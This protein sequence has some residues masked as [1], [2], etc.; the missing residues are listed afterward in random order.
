LDIPVIEDKSM[1]KYLLVILLISLILAGCVVS[2]LNPLY[3]DKDLILLPGLEGTWIDNDKNFWTFNKAEDNS[4]QMTYSRDTE[5]KEN[6]EVFDAHLVRLENQIFMDLFP[7]EGAFRDN[8]GMMAGHY[9]PTHTISKVQLNGDNLQINM[10]NPEWIKEM[11][12]ERMVFIGHEQVK[13]GFLL[14]ANSSDLQK[15]IS[16]YADDSIAFEKPA[17]ELNRFIIKPTLSGT[18]TSQDTVSI[19]LDTSS[20]AVSSSTTTMTASSILG[21]GGMNGCS[22]LYLTPLSNQ[23]TPK[24]SFQ[25]NVVLDNPLG[26]NVDNLGLW[27]RY[28]PKAVIF[29]PETSFVLDNNTFAGWNKMVSYCNPSKGELYLEFKTA[30]EG[31]PLSGTIG[32]IE[33]IA[34]GKESVSQIRFGFNRWGSFPST[35]LTYRNKDVLGKER[36]HNDGTISAMLRVLP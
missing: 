33:F 14:T 23:V 28:N 5:L 2:S 31:R 11:N 13:D 17:W 12:D 4:Y 21:S 32:K 16:T 3:T 26:T 9:I 20:P 6:A 1:K 27:I 34:T 7:R 10:L 8:K 15:F 36:D 35:F 25:L 18:T 24:S 19:S 30:N 29:K 22:I